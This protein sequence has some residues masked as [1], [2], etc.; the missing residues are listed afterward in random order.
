M[1]YLGKYTGKLTGYFEVKEDYKE[2]LLLLLNDNKSILFSYIDSTQSTHNF[3]VTI[4]DLDLKDHLFK[5]KIMKDDSNLIINETNKTFKL[6][7]NVVLEL[8]NNFENIYNN[9]KETEQYNMLLNI[10]FS[11]IVLKKIIYKNQN[12]RKEFRKY[13][14]MKL[15]FKYF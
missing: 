5:C 3:L 9:I 11:S 13:E 2:Q 8:N 14:P 1:N 6:N 12:D 4:K 15:E 10:N 7:E